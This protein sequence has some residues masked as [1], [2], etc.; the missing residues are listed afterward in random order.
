MIERAITVL[1][2][3]VVVS[4]WLLSILPVLLPYAVALFVMAIVARAVWFLT[5]QRR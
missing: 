1:I 2:V 3:T 5:Q 4:C